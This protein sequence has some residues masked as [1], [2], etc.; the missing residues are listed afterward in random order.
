MNG[1]IKPTRLNIE[2]E[3][4]IRVQEDLSYIKEWIK[5]QPYL[6]ARTGK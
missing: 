3:D 1:N 4:P 6:N 5:K 2:D